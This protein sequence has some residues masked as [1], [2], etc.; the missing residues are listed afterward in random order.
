MHYQAS[1]PVKTSDGGLRCLNVEWEKASWERGGTKTKSQLWRLQ[2]HVLLF[3]LHPRT[4]KQDGHMR[5]FREQPSYNFLRVTCCSQLLFV[6]LCRNRAGWKENAQ[7]LSR[8]W[9]PRRKHQ[10][11]YQHVQTHKAARGTSYKRSLLP[12]AFLFPPIKLFRKVKLLLKTF[13]FL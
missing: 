3:P 4:T 11:K 2:L 8:F 7:T 5:L 10:Q 12:L 13:H 6:S 9:I 1:R